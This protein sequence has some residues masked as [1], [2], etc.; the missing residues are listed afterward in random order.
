VGVGCSPPSTP[1]R[2]NDAM[3]RGRMLQLV[4]AVAIG[5]GMDEYLSIADTPAL[6]DVHARRADLAGQRKAE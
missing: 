5:A 1:N 3:I 4:E 2:A 6:G